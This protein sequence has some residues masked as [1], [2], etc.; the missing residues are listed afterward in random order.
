MGK[1][2]QL[3]G[4]L[5]SLAKRDRVLDEIKINQGRLLALQMRTL[6]SERLSDYEFKVFSQW[7]EDGILQHLTT[8][9]A[10][11]NKTFIEFGIEDFSE[12]NCRFL[13]MKDAWRGYVID[14]SKKN[15]ERLRA[16]YYFWRSDIQAEAAFVTR[17]SI[18]ALLDRSGFDKDLGILSIDIDGVDYFIFEKL[19][20][21]RPCILVMEYNALFGRER[22]VTVPYAADFERQTAHYSNLYYGASLAALDHLARNRGYAFVGTNSAASNAFFVRRDLL[23]EVVC[24]RPLSSAPASAPFREGRDRQGALSFASH[25]ERLRLVGHLPLVDVVTGGE[26][27]VA[28]LTQ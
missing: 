16:S 3:L 11:P 21:W 28:D 27:R 24:E 6:T 9:I 8:H 4:S 23:N 7:G 26:L 5:K 18:T 15:I 12:S 20:A 10:I 2:T 14:G 1:L 19:D 17:E 22:A 13:M 25:A